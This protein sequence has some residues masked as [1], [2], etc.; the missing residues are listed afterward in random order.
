MKLKV[1]SCIWKQQQQPRDKLSWT[2]QAP[3]SRPNKQVFVL[4]VEYTIWMSI[5][6]RRK[7]IVK[8]QWDRTHLKFQVRLACCDKQND[9]ILQKHYSCTR[10]NLY[11]STEARKTK[12]CIR[13]ASRNVVETICQKISQLLSSWENCAVIV[14]KP[15][16]VNW[17]LAC[18][19]GAN[20][21]PLSVKSKT[22]KRKTEP[23]APLHPC[24]FMR[25]SCPL[26]SWAR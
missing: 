18:F 6:Y 13:I 14:S 7:V 9:K 5:V 16:W 23:T 15:S 8:K 11:P 22:K 24:Y 26:Q 12:K 3:K 25:E 1:L 4:A 10:T 2:F 19:Y 21:E 20:F 17:K